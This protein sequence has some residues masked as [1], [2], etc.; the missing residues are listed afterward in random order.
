ML[1]KAAM[2]S[3]YGAPEVL[4]MAEVAR[5]EPRDDEVRIA[6]R[7]TTATA[8]CGLMRRGDTAMARM[9]LGVLRPRR[10]F[11]ILGTELAGVIDAVGSKVTRFRPGDRVYGFTG[12]KA[13]AYA[14]YVCLS[15]TA[16]IAPAPAGVSDFEAATL[17]DGP[18]TALY[19]LRD[20]AHLLPGARLAIVGASGSIGTA[21]V[22]IARYLGAHVTAV[23]SGKNAELVRSLGAHEVVDYTLRDYTAQGHRYDV[24]F[25]TVGKSAFRQAS[26]C[27]VDGGTY[28]V[29]VGGLSVMVL[30]LLTRGF[31]RT[32]LSFG[33]SVEKREALRVVATLTE[34]GVLRP[35]IDRQYPLAQVAEAHRYVE[36]GRKR[37]NVVLAVA[38][39]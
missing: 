21:A 38:E 36:T 2:Y 4:A 35:V 39:R 18:T 3:R 34:A 37:G 23:C 29:T 24:V 6:I 33:F 16:S 5:P 15:E 8:A 14:E 26:R 17:V 25:D 11:R 32:R 7:A 19:F 22:Q 10:R 9:V 13:G 28:L 27:L 31:S 20:R 12:M 30:D 1:M